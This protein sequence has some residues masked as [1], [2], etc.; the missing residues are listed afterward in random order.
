MLLRQH[1][2]RWLGH[3][4]RMDDTQIPTDLLYGELTT[5]KRNVGRP[6]LRFRDVWKR[7]MR[8]C[9]IDPNTWEATATD[10]AAW[11][12]KAGLAQVEQN[13]MA[14]NDEERSRMK[15][16]QQM[17]HSVIYDVPAFICEAYSRICRTRA[18][19]TTRTGLTRLFSIVY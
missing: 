13:I 8:P 4:Y 18:V 12:C 10:R 11:S 17:D 1:R 6:Y 7:N 2:L 19:L 3:I 9:N 15:E 16:N 14:L 5:G